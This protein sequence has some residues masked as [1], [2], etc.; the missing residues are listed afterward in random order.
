MLFIHTYVADTYL[1]DPT[2]PIGEET[3]CLLCMLLFLWLILLYC[4][5]LSS[6]CLYLCFHQINIQAFSVVSIALLSVV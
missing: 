2:L 5:V 4:G 1:S 3:I 6:V